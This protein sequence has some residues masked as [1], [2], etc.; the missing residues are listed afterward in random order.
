MGRAPPHSSG[1][2]YSGVPISVPT[3]VK[4]FDGRCGS[5]CDTATGVVQRT[6]TLLLL[7]TTGGAPAGV[8]EASPGLPWAVEGTC[9]SAVDSPADAKS[10]TLWSTKRAMPKSSSLTSPPVVSMTLAGLRSVNSNQLG[11]SVK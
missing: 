5:P 8:A 2:I 3:R 1:A 9:I 4:R 11:P 7:V 6:L 10:A